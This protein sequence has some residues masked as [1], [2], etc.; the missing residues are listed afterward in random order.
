MTIAACT[1]GADDGQD[2]R[3][4]WRALTEAAA[5]T[6]RRTGPVVEVTYPL[7]AGEELD[8]LVNAE[9][10]CCQF[11]D[12]DIIRRGD[13]LVLHIAADPE[14]PADIES[15]ADLFGASLDDG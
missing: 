11:V 9:R 15:F 12:W 14:R 8:S 13:S 7:D 2:R 4:R 10:Q 6:A 3:R 5:P 1:L